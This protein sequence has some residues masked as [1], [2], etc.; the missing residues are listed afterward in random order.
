MIRILDQLTVGVQQAEIDAPAINADARDFG[1]GGLCR[2]ADTGLDFSQ[3]PV[4]VPAQR[5]ILFDRPIAKTVDFLKH[6][7][8]R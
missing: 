5:A 1:A 7:F 6:D 8:I 2:F 4:K 3:Q